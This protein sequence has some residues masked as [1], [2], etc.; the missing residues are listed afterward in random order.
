MV[1]RAAF[2]VA[3]VAV[4]V[5]V[6]VELAVRFAL[7]F[8]WLNLNLRLRLWPWLRLWLSCAAEL[9][10]VVCSWLP[11][12]ALPCTSLQFQSSFRLC[13]FACGLRGRRSH[14]GLGGASRAAWPQPLAIWAIAIVA[15]VGRPG[16]HCRMAV[17]PA[18]G[19]AVVRSARRGGARNRR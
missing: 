7:A 1:A 3:V 6:D 10:F 13:G 11:D 19:R 18:D 17:R 15:W 12:R 16:P 5:A 2:A 14:F 9:W 4:V 8:F